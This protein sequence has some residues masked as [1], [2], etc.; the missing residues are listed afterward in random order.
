MEQSRSRWA[1]GAA[2][3]KAAV[4]AVLGLGGLTFVGTTA[5]FA[6]A[7]TITSVCV[8]PSMASTTCPTTP[9]STGTANGGT[10]VLV[11]GTAFGTTGSIS[12]VT[13][14]GVNATAFSQISGLKVTATIPP[15]HAPTAVVDV[16]VT[17]TGGTTAIT[18]ADQYTYTWSATPIV[19]SISPAAGPIAGGTTVT[20]TGKDIAGASAVS[21]GST[22]ATSVTTATSTTLTAVAPAGAAGPVDVTVTTPG[23]TTAVTP[24]ADTYSYVTTPT[25]TSISSTSTP[26]GGPT[27]GGT[28]VMINGTGFANVT[29][30]S[31]GSTAATSY[32]V[33]SVGSISAVAP[34]GT[35]TVDVTVTTALGTTATSAADQF[36][37][38]STLAL[39]PA[40]ASYSTGDSTGAAAYAIT[41]S[42]QSGGNVILTA[43][44]SFQV[45]QRVYLS[46]M[47]N[48][49]PTGYATITVGGS[50]SFGVAGT[51][52]GTGTGTAVGVQVDSFRA[53]TQV[54]G[55]GNVDPTTL[56]VVTQPAS[57]TLSV[58]NG[59]LMY[60]PAST[61]P[62]SAVV[63]GATVWTTHV[64]TTGTQTATYA[65]C[66]QGSTYPG[67]GCTTGT[68][69]YVQ[70][71]TGFSMGGLAVSGAIKVA[72]VVDNGAG[73]IVPS[74]ATSGGTIT[75]VTAPPQANI[76]IT[77]SGFTVTSVSGYAAIVPVPTGL[78]VVPGSLKVSG[79]DP[80]SSGKYIATVCTAA[81]G[82]IPGQCTATTSGPNF[83]LFHYPYIESVLNSASAI[84]GGAQLTLP[85]VTAQF[86]VTAT[87]GS[88]ITG[89]ET[90]FGLTTNVVTIGSVALDTY[91][92]DPLA[93][94]GLG[95][96]APAY[97]AP[98]PR[99]S[100]NVI[101][102]ATTPS[103]TTASVTPSTTTFGSSVAYGATVTGSGAT[104][105]GT[106]TFTDGATTLCTA[107]LAAGTGS[108]NA[109]NAPVGASQT[110]TAT[111][112]GDSTY[113]ASSDATK[114]LTVNKASSTTTVTCTAGPFTY[115]GAAQ[116]PCSATV[117]GAGGLSTTA[118]VT[119]GSNTNAGTATADATYAGDTDHNGSTATQVTFTI[120]K[121]ASTTT[122]TCP[123]TATYTGSALTPCTATATGVGG[124]STSASV[125]YGSNT[126][127]GTATADSTYA[128]DTNHNGST[129]TQVTFAITKATPTT[130][131]LSNAP[132]TGVVGDTY[133]AVVST[134]G[135]GVTS[136]T[137]TGACTATALSVTFTGAG[138]CSVTPHVAAG[139]N[140][141]A[142]DGAP[143]SITVVVGASKLGV[144]APATAA[145]G[146]SFSVTVTAQTAGG[147]TVPTY[148]GT[149]H[150]TS[151]DPLATLPANYTFVPGDNGVHTFT[152][153]QLGTAGHQT[154]TVTDTV[155]SSIT[156][157][158]GINKDVST[159]TAFVPAPTTYGATETYGALVTGAAGTPTGSVVFT[160]GAT[161]LCTATL[162]SG[163][164]NCTA[165][166]APVGNAQTVTA[167]YSGDSAYSGSTDASKTLTVAKAASTTT[168]TC[169]GG[170]FTYTGAAQTPCSATVTGAGGLSTTATVTYGSNTNAGTATAD[171]TYAGDANHNGSTATQVTFTIGKAASTTTV[172][173]TGGPFTYTGAAI[174]P[175]SATVTG[176]GGLS[177]TAT[178]T[179]G[180]NTNA[181]TA[182][183]N[184]AYAGDANHN[185][186]T[187][188]QAT[189]TIAKASS[190][191]TVS[192]PGGPFAYTG[193]AITP[194][195]ATVTGAG[196]LSTTATVTYTNNT[197]AGSATANAAYAGDA[198]HNGSTATPVNFTITGLAPDAPG[199]PTATS[200]LPGK[201]TVSW[202]APASNGGSP[203]TGYTV[204][205]APDGLTCTT[206]G[207]QCT[208]S[209]LTGGTSYT[210]T[211]TATNAVGTSPDSTP[212][213]AVVP[214][215]GNVPA[216]GYWFAT[217]AGAVLTNGAAVSFGSPAGLALNAPIVGFAPTG[218]RQGYW[219][220]GADGGVFS[221]GDAAFYGSAGDLHLNQPIVGIAPTPDGQGYWLVG[222]D[223]GVFSYGDAAFYGSAGDLHLNKPIVG[224]A[225]TPDGTGYWLVASDGG[226]FAYGSAAFYGST[227]DLNLVKPIVGI[228]STLD[229]TG[230]WMVAADGG[231]FAF[232]SAAFHGSAAGQATS[233]V[234]SITTSADDG[235]VIGTAD[236]AAYAF[237]TTSYGSQVGT[238]ITA[239]IISIAS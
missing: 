115:T 26:A 135:D 175:C 128:G 39:A 165:S 36:A 214:A 207:L 146:S 126:N 103:T 48:G 87:G 84:P 167:T 233:P 50:G 141:A 6:A 31:F 185:G 208:V 7:P 85:T 163:S 19:S 81:M 179:Y 152:G 75:T 125:T 236:G 89:Y 142:A 130:P 127:V 106:V 107:T 230:Y 222:A 90:E 239:P 223:G 169:P 211:V 12:A 69:S 111:Y 93:T 27:G 201:A 101:G 205:S 9:I 184:A 122:I 1:H 79:G 29:G 15:A 176:A 212:S 228:T 199:T 145:V 44:G 187:A 194:C 117:T 57:G 70:A 204:T 59:Q 49:L 195:S 154:I 198:N 46:G 209:G 13:V 188:T 224:I 150:F 206:S 151:S 64:T 105:T 45:G 182:T 97:V 20:I 238:P 221:Y 2:V 67:A 227:G 30:V 34:A 210:F 237:G 235:Y 56:T 38:S 62:T 73:L 193:A 155:T 123:A 65:I 66:N 35:G 202:S 192:C 133:I 114:T 203:I 231:V 11:T 220:V 226:V 157:T 24:S 63:S 138:T 137:A 118:T 71:S 78:S 68:I 60:E 119:Y 171:A 153:V 88:T 148:A 197:N 8:V 98:S 108:C 92:C 134:T 149:V 191:T 160:I 5:A 61:V 164:G 104:P 55:G 219:M 200:T 33:N 234:V 178:V 172:S 99:Y 53:S 196:G 140:Y 91:P 43:V 21:F 18:S 82:Y 225:A 72:V 213:N 132:A 190:T 16:R 52:T 139:A 109:S 216:N 17:S 189:F 147:A 143:V 174:T 232:G 183:A 168:V 37:Y 4:A 41:A 215:Q 77:N 28:Q 136:V 14:G 96:P 32:S 83:P 186:S 218:S 80:N 42:A 10:F 144:T 110:I 113:L 180:S 40:T 102:G 100:I 161:T 47:T 120:G 51:Q 217:S 124:L 162:S 121:A 158:A 229:G 156:G 116:T 86:T 76:P 23:G 159:T 112:S 58:A 94:Q 74:S 166:N 3:A 129:A 131:T 173:C 54:T 95:A 22:A 170:P 177:T 25:V 181:G